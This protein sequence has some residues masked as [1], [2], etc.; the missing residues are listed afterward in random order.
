M[1]RAVA[2]STMVSRRGFTAVELLI[3]LGI[4]GTLVGIAVPSYMSYLE[5]AKVAKAIGDIRILD[6]DIQ[7][8]R[9]NNDKLPSSL[10]DIGKGQ[11]LD[12]Y[13]NAYVYGNYDL[14]KPGNKRKDQFL[15]P[16]N[17]DYDLY[18]KGQDGN[19]APP[20]TAQA[21]RDDIVRANDGSY[22]GLASNY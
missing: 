2:G 21:S 11:L 16:L 4:F 17:S 18:S 9:H 10:N 14:I 20:L 19:S 15:V 6:S 5:R 7:L 1:A 12:P 3:A 8:F 13:G 22:V